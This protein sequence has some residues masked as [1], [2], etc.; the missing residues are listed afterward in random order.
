LN[1]ILVLP[2][3]KFKKANKMLGE[4]IKDFGDIPLLSH[5]ELHFEKDKALESFN[6]NLNCMKKSFLNIL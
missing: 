1:P 2:D 3:K 6:R 4:L 5:L